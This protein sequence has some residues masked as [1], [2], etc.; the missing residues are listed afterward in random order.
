MKKIVSLKYS[1]ILILLF[2]LIFQSQEIKAQFANGA[3]I[4]WL[5]EMEDNGY[6]FKNDSGITKNCMEILKEKGINALRFRVWVNPRNKYCSKQDVAYMTQRA[7]S[8]GFSV[9]LDFHLSDTWADPGHQTKPAA[10]LTHTFTQLKTDVYNHIYDV[11]DTLKSH[12]VTPKWVQVGNETNN[13]MLWEDGRASTHMN[14]FAELIK[15]GY[16][17]VKAIDTTIQVI[18]HLSNGHDINMYRWMFDGLKN[19]G[20][21]WDIIGMSVYPHWANLPWAVDDSLALITM[22]DMISRYNTKVMVCEAGY[23]Y[24]EPVEANHY[25]LD[26]IEKTKSVGGLGVFYWEP[27]SY[28]WRGYNMGAWDP[29]TKQPTVALDAFLGIKAI[30]HVNITM[31]INTATCPDTLRPSDIVQVRGESTGSTTLTW[32]N[33]SP[34]IAT[35]KGGDYWEAT[36]QAYPGDNI[37]Y[38]FWTGFSLI[39]ET[40]TSFNTG[41]EGPIDAGAPSDNNRLFIVGNNDTTLALQYYH[42][43]ANAVAQY[44]KPFE[45]KEDSVAVYFRVNMAGVSSIGRFDPD[46]NG[47]VGIR[48]DPVDSSNVLSWDETKAILSREELS[49]NSGSFWSGIVYYPLTTVGEIQYYGFYIENDTYNGWENNVSIRFFVIPSK[50]TTINWVSFDNQH[51]INSVEDENNLVSG[52]KLYQNY[53]NPFNPSTQINYDLKSR[54][55]VKLTVYNSLGQKIETLVNEVQTS[56]SHSLKFN[57]SSSLPS[58][59]YYIHLTTDYGTKSIKALLLK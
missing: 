31:R 51:I 17:A 21:K 41:W 34:V 55:K 36:F 6:I 56:G 42:G 37:R 18:V 4:G 40:G 49:V 2:L 1:L 3:D 15:S 13:G 43:D 24:D 25:L 12:G 44:W 27:E 45:Q 32:N 54:T 8:M 48:G 58:G 5:S 46:V 20:V 52:F 38:K 26:L 19:N 33:T 57:A 11:L 28:N 14:N 59:V 30:E 39:P 47:P 10:W 9:M 16:D 23:S 7:V 35:N 29:V 53:P 50:D 22:E